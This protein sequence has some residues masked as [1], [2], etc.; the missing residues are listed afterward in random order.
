[1]LIGPLRDENLG[2]FQHRNQSGGDQYWHW[3]TWMRT[4]NSKCI[5][6]PEWE[7]LEQLRFNTVELYGRINVKIWIV[8]THLHINFLVTQWKEMRVLT[9]SVRI[10]VIWGWQELTMRWK[11]QRILAC[12]VLL[13]L[14]DKNWLE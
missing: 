13:V 5:Q 12:V 10:V 3:C 6:V 8:W 9:D 7:L 2:L 14:Y 11:V 4:L 1:M